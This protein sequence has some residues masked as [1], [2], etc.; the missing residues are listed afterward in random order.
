MHAPGLI[1]L[2]AGGS[3]RMGQPKQL[4]PFGASTL[5]RHAAETA[6]ATACHPVIVVIGREAARCQ[7]E[8]VGLD[9]SPVINPD[10]PQGIGTSI[11]AGVKSLN[12]LNSSSPG[13]LLMLVDQPDV[14]SSFLGTIVARWLENKDFIVGTH[15]P[16]GGGVPA[17]FPRRYFD[18]LAGLNSDQGARR[19]IAR[20]DSAALL[21]SPPKQLLDVD[22]PE[23]YA[24]IR[25]SQ[26][27]LG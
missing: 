25:S 19:V 21:I 23:S 22:T 9:V 24:Q 16:E 15:Y 2:A 18:E 8:L 27:V 14:T 4:L 1:L 11:A 13:A 26:S 7:N 5:L 12:R 3:R 6:L 10:W 17:L 20:K